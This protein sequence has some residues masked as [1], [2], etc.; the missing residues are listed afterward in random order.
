[1]YVTILSTIGRLTQL[2][3]QIIGKYTDLELVKAV[4][5]SAPCSHTQSTGH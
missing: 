2:L 4:A 1:M 5:R 3:N